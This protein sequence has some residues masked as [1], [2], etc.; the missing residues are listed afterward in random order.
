MSKARYRN[1][2]N[3]Y[4]VAVNISAYWRRIDQSGGPQACWPWQGPW[5]RQGYGFIGGRRYRDDQR[6][7]LVAHR[8]GMRI[9]LGRA[10]DRSEMVIHTCSNPAC[11][12]FRHL[13]LGDAKSRTQNMYANGRNHPMP[14]GRNIRD[15]R[16]QNRKYRRTIEEM[17]WIRAHRP[18]EIAD[19]FGIDIHRA[20]AW[21]AG[22]LRGYSWLR[23]YED[24]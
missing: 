9:K 19:R 2:D 11:Q 12:N 20:C 3:L 6:V 21:R 23:D 17:L 5:H 13:V 4:D 10:I 1:L 18:R 14:R 7:M 8:V 15:G 22:Y 16:Q 24:K